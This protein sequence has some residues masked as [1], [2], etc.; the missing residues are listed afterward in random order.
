MTSSVGGVGRQVVERAAL[1]EIEAYIKTSN[2]R[3]QLD[4]VYLNAYPD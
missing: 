4:V 1:R 2:A 3:D